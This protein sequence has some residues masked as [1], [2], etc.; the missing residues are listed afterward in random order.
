VYHQTYLYIRYIC[1]PFLG[2]LLACFP[3]SG[4]DDKVSIGG[5]LYIG[6]GYR[7]N[8]V[9]SY[10]RQYLVLNS[11][12]FYDLSG[13]L[14]I[15]VRLSP[16]FKAKCE[17]EGD[18]NRPGL[19]IQKAY[20][21]FKSSDT[22]RFR[23]G[24]MKM[25]ISYEEELSRMK[26]TTIYRS[27]L[28]EHLENLLYTGYMMSLQW[29]GTY[30]TGTHTTWNTALSLSADGDTRIYG[31]GR[32]AL[33]TG[34]WEQYLSVLYVNRT[35]KNN[36]SFLLSAGSR[37]VTKKLHLIGELFWGKNQPATDNLS[38]MGI[39]STI[40]SSGLRLGT[41]PYFSTHRTYMH[42]IEPV[43]TGAIL[44][45][46]NKRPTRALGQIQS[47]LNFHFVKKSKIIWKNNCDLVISNYADRNTLEKHYWALYSHMQAR[48]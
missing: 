19:N 41:A 20:I 25:D 27:I 39:K 21:Q 29:R 23:I 12:Y 9:D 42:G 6:A 44:V 38:R 2:I 24:N 45:A 16:A 22:R 31:N 34:H 46:D 11:K 18:I 3:C 15:S 32:V 36:S 1:Y 35:Y 5:H 30:T 47:G 48:W 14:D 26:R 7:D 40:Y 28:Y 10:S 33:K 17:F 43:L 13:E 4:K 8:S 37:K